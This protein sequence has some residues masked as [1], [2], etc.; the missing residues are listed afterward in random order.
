MEIIRKSAT[1]LQELI[2]DLVDVS[3]ITSGK[4]RLELKPM[5]LAPLLRAAIDGVR[6]AAGNK[7]QSITEEIDDGLGAA[8]LDPVRLQQVVSNVLTNA[9]KFT[10]EKGRIVVKTRRHGD[11]VEIQ[12]TDSGQGIAADF[13]PHVFDRFRQAGEATTR[14]TSGL[15]LGLAIA[16]Q[17]VDLHGGS[18]TAASAG[19]GKGS[20]FTVRLPLPAIDA[21]TVPDRNSTPPLKGAPHL[22]GRRI[23]LIEDSTNTRE[24]LSSILRKTGA[25][26]VA[27]GEAGGALAEF[28]RQ[29]PD[30]VLSDLGL[31][32]VD[33]LALLHQI[34]DWEKTQ[35][36]RPIPALA[37]TAYTD[38][39]NRRKAVESGFDKTLTKPVD[40]EH[41]IA[42]LAGLMPG[43]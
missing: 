31:P 4:L 21:K 30:I 41:L 14:G 15:G 9:I 10:P 12:V 34:R 7:Q 37:L 33:G 36:I 13:L 23:L 26:V 35:K 29:Q 39:K 27:F 22:K 5:H 17:L 25:V 32:K 8:R 20:T 43:Q 3:R 40:P 28:Q 19:A 2:E 6:H 24:A 42:V 18:I 1:E 16:K 11:D 38:D